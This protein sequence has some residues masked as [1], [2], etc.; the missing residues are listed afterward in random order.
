MAGYSYWHEVLQYNAGITR[1]RHLTGSVVSTMCD[2]T[3]EEPSPLYNGV[4]DTSGT[5]LGL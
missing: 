5:D 4:L 1:Q 2:M 3:E